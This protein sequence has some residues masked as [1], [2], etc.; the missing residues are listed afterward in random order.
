[1]LNPI[2]SAT[3]LDP[4]IAAAQANAQQVADTQSK[5]TGKSNSGSS[6]LPRDVVTLSHSSEAESQEGTEAPSQT[7]TDGSS[8]TGQEAS[9]IASASTQRQA[10]LAYSQ[11]GGST[12]A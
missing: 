9:L 6:T 12:A 8:G 7:D 4:S 5:S 2:N 1:M 11:N 3:H 10:A